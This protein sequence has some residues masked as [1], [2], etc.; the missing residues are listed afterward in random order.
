MKSKIEIEEQ[1]EKEGTVTIVA[2]GSNIKC[3]ENTSGK[4]DSWNTLLMFT[5]TAVVLWDHSIWARFSQAKIG[6]DDDDDDK[7]MNF[8]AASK[9]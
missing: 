3:R 5:C 6:G 1:Q 2:I 4:A 8:L 9:L 7:I